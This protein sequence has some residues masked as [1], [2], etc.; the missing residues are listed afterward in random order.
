M[1]WKIEKNI[2]DT[3]EADELYYDEEDAVEADEPY[4]ETKEADAS[5]YET[6]GDEYDRPVKKH[7]TKAPVK[8]TGEHHTV[9]KSSN[10]KHSTTGKHTSR[11]A[12]AEK[13]HTKRTAPAGVSASKKKSR[14]RQEEATF[15]EKLAFR[16]HKMTGMDKLVA[17]TGVLVLCVAIVTLSIFTTARAAEKQAEA[18][19]PI[20]ERLELLET[21][22]EDTL[23]AV[24]DARRAM[25]FIEDEPTEEDTYEEKEADTDG[26]VN[27]TMTLTSMK[28]DLK[29]KFINSKTKKLVP[30]V[31]FQVTIK[32]A[33]GKSYT[34]E[35]DDKDGIIY[36]KDMTPGEAS[37]TME[38]LDGNDK[39]TVDTKT[40]TVTIKE[41]IDYKKVDV[42][43]EVKKESQV[44]AK[45]EDTAAQ[46]V[47]EAALTDT[48][49]WVESTKTE[50]GSSGGYIEV[51]KSNVAEPGK[52]ARAIGSFLKTAAFDKTALE[53]QVTPIPTPEEPTQPPAGEP[54]PAEPTP[55]PAEPSPS[56]AG[57]TPTAA[58]SPTAIPTPTA[59]PTVTPTTK[60][61]ATPTVKPT[62]SPTPSKIVT[63][64]PTAKPASTDTKTPLKDKNGNQMFIKDSSGNMWKL[65]MQ[66]IINTPPF[67]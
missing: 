44:N 48:V 9:K 30:S 11:K 60:P 65:S 62:A 3:G 10:G 57:P 38:A 32:D 53:E 4:Y 2:Q 49:T 46:N 23:L 45:V 16:L 33:D 27:V 26:T 40:H 8:Q 17:A 61:T 59:K 22:G 42:S 39:I 36:L 19:I 51:N 18:M 15:F 5:Y 25:T 24:A 13:V 14:K 29:I 41:N 47:V 34:K 64:T 6:D 52:S 31:G 55:S 50:V 43:D 12:A 63:P 54:S 20:G 21:A 28:K 35:D 37:V 56:P 67:I 7:R 66:I 58:P 1:A